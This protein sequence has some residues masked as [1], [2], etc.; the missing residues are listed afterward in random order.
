MEFSINMKLQLRDHLPTV[1][2]AQ[3]VYLN[4]QDL[5]SD[6]FHRMTSYCLYQNFAKWTGTI[7]ILKCKIFAPVYEN[8]KLTSATFTAVAEARPAIY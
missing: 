1:H 6:S 4:H 5:C 7:R 3:L 8:G 2:I